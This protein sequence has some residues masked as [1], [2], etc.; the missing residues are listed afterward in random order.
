MAMSQGYQ[1]AMMAPTEILARQHADTLHNLLLPL[2]LSDEVVMLIGALS[3]TQKKKAHEAIRNG[4][5]RLIIGTQALIQEGV[6][7][8]R[9]GLV[10]IDE[11]HR[12]GCGAA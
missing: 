4:A 7:M 8:H 12:F 3:E 2:G 9:L 1:V 10:I 11:Q 6:D 5:A